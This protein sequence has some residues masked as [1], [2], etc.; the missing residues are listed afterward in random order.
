LLRDEHIAVSL[1]ARDV[2]AVGPRT[3]YAAFR[4]VALTRIISHTAL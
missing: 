4:T 1:P 2:D 3:S